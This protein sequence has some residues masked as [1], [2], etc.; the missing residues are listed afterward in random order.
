MELPMPKF[1]KVNLDEEEIAYLNKMITTGHEK[2]AK[3]TRARILLKA[4]DGWTDEAI[5]DAL[6]VSLRTI[7]RLRRRFAEE[8]LEASLHRR[9]SKRVYERLLD[10]KAEAHLI[11]LACSD[12]PEGRS[13]WTFRLLAEHLVILDEVDIESVSHETVRQVLKKKNLSLGESS[14]G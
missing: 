3:L 10:G 13:R 1:Y 14:S 8:G 5:K 6:D 4:N 12:P 2:A 9:N 7:E 11:K